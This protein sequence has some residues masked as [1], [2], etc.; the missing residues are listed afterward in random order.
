MANRLW[1]F[2]W[3]VTKEQKGSNVSKT[4]FNS[5]TPSLVPPNTDGEQ[6]NV[7]TNNGGSPSITTVNVARDFPWTYSPP[8]AVARAE[9]P[10]AYLLE[11]RLK[12][13]ALMS[14]IAYSFANAQLGINDITT[15]LQRNGGA[16]G[17]SFINILNKLKDTASNEFYLQ[18]GNFA[19]ATGAGQ[20]QL[21]ASPTQEQIN[22][23][24]IALGKQTA[25][26]I[27]DYFQR[28]AGDSNET[29]NTPLLE[30]YKGLYP[31]VNTGWKYVL[32]YFEDY[33][34]SS[35]NIFGDDSGNQNLSN[36]IK[37]PGDLLQSAAGAAGALSAPFGFSFQEKAKFYNFPSEGEEFS[38]TFPL[39]NTGNIDF[40]QV[41]K[42]WQFLFLLLYQNKPSRI[43]RNII[44]PPVVYEVG[45]PGQK[46]YPFCYMTGLEVSFKGSR[47]E[48]EF[49][50]DFQN[51]VELTTA[52]TGNLIQQMDA[53]EDQVSDIA[54]VTTSQK[55]KAIIPDAYM[56]KI[57]LKSL[58]A[59]TRNFMAYTILGRSL[60]AVAARV[61]NLDTVNTAD[62]TGYLGGSNVNS[63]SNVGNQPGT[64]INYNVGGWPDP[65]GTGGI[66]TPEFTARKQ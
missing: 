8:G 28:I 23:A 43:N 18:T 62:N 13:N 22:Q 2:K 21:P 66:I 20:L 39:I 51:T 12:T 37:I 64:P 27:Q 6:Y 19:V 32:P 58:V 47:R 44:E 45:I 57:N 59:E 25:S 55:F 46:F 16:A 14:S 15:F 26:N 41:V 48:L 60:D 36:L 42:N 56:V 10:K 49:N 61:Q 7:K 30:A 1:S 38:L 53:A 35:Q 63:G 33:Y 9:T 40:N 65:T 24:K 11:K 50:L 3:D 31:T 5:Y 52:P 34:S 29:L 4:S 17:D 54:S